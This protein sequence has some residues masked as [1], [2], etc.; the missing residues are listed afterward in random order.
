MVSTEVDAPVPDGEVAP[1]EVHPEGCLAMTALGIIPLSPEGVLKR[2][3]P[4]NAPVPVQAECRGGILNA[5][6]ADYGIVRGE[7]S[8][9]IPPFPNDVVDPHCCF[10]MCTPD[11]LLARVNNFLRYAPF[12]DSLMYGW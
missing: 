6:V 7:G 11:S 2:L 8:G 10:C 5:G 3:L 12:L 4:L 9:T 1:I